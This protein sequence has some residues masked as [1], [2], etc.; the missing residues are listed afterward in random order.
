MS[1]NSRLSAGDVSTMKSASNPERFTIR[2]TLNLGRRGG[3]VQQF[4]GCV[5]CEADDD[6]DRLH[7]P[8]PSNRGL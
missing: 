7:R 2:L 5:S 3:V 1:L 4:Q 6:I 8:H